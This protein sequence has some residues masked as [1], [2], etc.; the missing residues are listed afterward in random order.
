M[1]SS[2]SPDSLVAFV[3]AIV[4]PPAAST[5]GSSSPRPL[6]Q[7]SLRST[8][9]PQHLHC[10][11]DQGRSLPPLQI[12]SSP[13]VLGGISKWVRGHSPYSLVDRPPRPQK[14][15]PSSKPMQ[16]RMKLK[17]TLLKLELH[18]G[19]EMVREELEKVAIERD[20]PHV[21]QYCSDCYVTGSDQWGYCRK[22]R[23]HPDHP[24][25]D[26]PM[27]QDCDCDAGSFCNSSP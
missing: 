15:R 16:V 21:A 19:K 17:S 5:S 27:L 25:H 3:N 22:S 26:C 13:F 8:P 24:R 20:A 11:L 14:C 23:H 18:Y 7:S 9:P 4:P 6:S 2:S 12:S 10:C 1:P